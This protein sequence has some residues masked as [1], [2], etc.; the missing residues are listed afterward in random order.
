MTTC[1]RFETGR[2][3][4]R[5][6]H[7]TRFIPLLLFA[8]ISACGLSGCALP[9]AGR[10]EP[11]TGPVRLFA[12]SPLYKIGKDEAPRPDWTPGRVALDCARNEAESF[13]LVARTDQPLTGLSLRIAAMSG[14]NGAVLPAE[15]AAVRKVEWVDINAPF[16]PNEPSKNPLLRPDPLAPVSPDRDRFDAQPGQ[17]M[18]FWIT[19]T[20]PEAARPGPYVGR[21]DLV[22]GEARA[23]SLRLEMNVRRFALPR[24]PLLRSMVGLAAGNIYKAH[25]CKTQDEKEKAIRLYFDEYA[26]ARLSPFLYAPGT[27]AF[28]PLPDACMKW[29]FVKGPDGKLTG[30]A[31]LDCAGFD[32][33]AELYFNQRQAFRAFNVAPYLWTARKQDGKKETRLRFADATGTAVERRNADGTVNPLFDQLVLSVFRQLTGHLA[34]KGWL[35]RAVY[36]VTD[37]PADDDTPMIKEICEL[38]RQAD[39]RLPTALTYDPANRPR[40]AELVDKDGKSLISIWVPYVTQYREEVAADQRRKGA[41]YWLYDVSTTCLISHS[42]ELNRGMFWEV[43]RRDAYGYLYYLSTWWGRSATPWDRP[44]FLLPEFTYRYRQGD[45]YFFYPPLRTYDPEPPI[46]DRLVTSIRWELMREGAEDYDCLRMLENL[47]DDA[48]K[49]GLAVAGRGRDALAHAR[50]VAGAVAPGLSGYAIRD[51]QFEARQEGAG[52]VP[53][54]GWSFSAQEGWLHHPGRRRSDLPITMAV[55]LPDGEY[56]LIL[57]VYDDPAYRGRPYSR[58]LV[59]GKPYATPGA[60]LKGPANVSVGI[61]TVRDGKCSFTL[62]SVEEDSGVILYRV[63]LRSAARLQGGILEARARVADAIEAIQAALDSK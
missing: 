37:E 43:W 4:K 53:G 41:T 8:A 1:K 49:R 3:A 27:Q 35:D 39:P 30:E 57:N 59:N 16:D 5:N 21:L 13:Q 11:Q 48:E 26:R 50:D 63:A 20:V 42:G 23:A 44:S 9:D 40:L 52:A 32:R 28:N 19:I 60:A 47:T 56:E 46:L 22:A 2:I 58:F 18:V 55:T 17:N 34:A 14:P 33:E 6:R 54:K 45:G 12:V 31:K 10:A 7:R 29:E 51:L 15:Q 61:V 38:I 25:G 24:R 36:Y 62:S